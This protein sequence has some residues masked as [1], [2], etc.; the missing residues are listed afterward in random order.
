MGQV[1]HHQTIC[2][3]RQ[4]DRQTGRQ[5]DRQT[6]RQTTPDCTHSGGMYTVKL[7][8]YFCVSVGFVIV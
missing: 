8:Y 7:W 5:A 6:D 1:A 4:T 3:D 2:T